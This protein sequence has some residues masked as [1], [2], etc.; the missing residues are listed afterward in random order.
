MRIQRSTK[1]THLQKHLRRCEGEIHLPQVPHLLQKDV[2]D[3]TN[4]VYDIAQQQSDKAADKCEKKSSKCSGSAHALSICCI[5]RS[6][7][8]PM[9]S[10]LAACDGRVFSLHFSPCPNSI[11]FAIAAGPSS[12]PRKASPC[13]FCAIPKL[14]SIVPQWNIFICQTVSTLA[15]Q[16]RKKDQEV[17][18][19][20]TLYK[21]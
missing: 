9:M 11:P 6:A 3:A 18:R 10:T 12:R 19:P 16:L 5:R 1:T 17:V 13:L 14:F 7:Y 8:V 20:I 4:A 15:G 2:H 21:K